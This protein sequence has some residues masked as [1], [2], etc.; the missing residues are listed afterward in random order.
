M[1]AAMWLCAVVCTTPVF[2]AERMNVSVCTE[3]HPGSKLVAEAESEASAVFRSLDVEIAWT[4]CRSAPIGEEAARQHWFTVRLRTGKPF[5]ATPALSLD[6]LGEAFF[7]DDRPAYLAEVYYEA[8]QQ[9]ASQ[10]D[11]EP[12]V[13]LGCV[14]AHE[15]GHL[16]LGPGHA[17]HGIMR[18]AWNNLELDEMRFGRLKFNSAESDQIRKVLEVS[19]DN[20]SGS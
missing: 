9:F 1:R 6:T 15:L 5:F 7:A 16:L 18:A 2:A 12:G 20:A 13:L 19:S 3:G 4:Q 8:V 10:R 17:P 11:V 14:I